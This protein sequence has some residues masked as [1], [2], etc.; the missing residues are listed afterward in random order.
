MPHRLILIV[1][2][3]ISIFSLQQPSLLSA[4][5]Q[6][7]LIHGCYHGPVPYYIGNPKSIDIAQTGSAVFPERKIQSYPSLQEE[8]SP[9]AYPYGY[10]G[11]QYRPY[12]VSHRNYYNDFSQ[13]SFRR[14][15]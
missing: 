2:F 10:F 12:S 6:Y 14:G 3:L 11:A 9:H 8:A 4:A 15:Y 5:E 1:L 13:W 7:G